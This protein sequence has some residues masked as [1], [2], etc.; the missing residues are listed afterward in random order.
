MRR[1]CVFV[2]GS[3]FDGILLSEMSDDEIRVMTD[4][5]TAFFESR[6]GAE[7]TELARYLKK[8]CDEA[9]TSRC[10]VIT[11]AAIELLSKYCFTNASWNNCIEPARALMLYFTGGHLVE[12]MLNETRDREPEYQSIVSGLVNHIQ[13]AM[14]A[15]LLERVR[16]S[17]NKLAEL[18]SIAN[19]NPTWVEQFLQQCT[20]TQC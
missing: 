15:E 6:S 11:V 2:S 9:R 4:L 20:S 7:F 14:E 13:R 16:V 3:W 1:S 12:R 18:N 5:Q 19:G 17:A 10:S 8:S